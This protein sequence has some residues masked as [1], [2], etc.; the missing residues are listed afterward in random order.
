[1]V[2]NGCGVRDRE[3]T[4]PVLPEADNRI[5]AAGKSLLAASAERRRGQRAL[6]SK[7]FDKIKNAIAPIDDA[8]ITN[9]LKHANKPSREQLLMALF[10]PSRHRLIGNLVERRGA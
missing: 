5:V 9:R 3:N 6:L 4:D 8:K 2:C 7:R 1:V 10:Q